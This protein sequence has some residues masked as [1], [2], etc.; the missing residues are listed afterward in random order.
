MRSFL[1]FTFLAFLVS[2][3]VGCSGPYRF[4]FIVFPD[5][6]NRLELFVNGSSVSDFDGNHAD[7]SNPKSYWGP[8]S[9]E[10]GTSASIE[11]REGSTVISSLQI[12]EGTYLVNLSRKHE[13]SYKPVI[14]T[15]EPM[16]N[17]EPCI[18]CE[19]GEKEHLKVGVYM[20]TKTLSIIAFPFNERPPNSVKEKRGDTTEYFQLMARPVKEL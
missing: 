8:K 5:P 12:E 17:K 6:D 2:T 7:S 4:R 11:I 13:L 1:K 18:R 15:I 20:M 10:E 19:L 16:D 3:L 14:Y 9:W